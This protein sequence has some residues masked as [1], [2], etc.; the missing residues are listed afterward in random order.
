L[1][2]TGQASFIQQHSS[3]LWIRKS[4]NAPAAGPQ[5]GVEPADL[6]EHLGH[7]RGLRAR[8]GRADDPRDAVGAQQEQL[9]DGAVADAVV[10]LAAGVAVPAHQADAHLQSAAVPGV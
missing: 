6:V 7:V 9:A 8:E 10:Q 1:A 5:E 3:M 2:S 4:L